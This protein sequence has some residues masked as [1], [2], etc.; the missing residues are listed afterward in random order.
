VKVGARVRVG[1]GVGAGRSKRSAAEQ[2]S[3]VASITKSANQKRCRCAALWL[4]V[5]GEIDLAAFSSG[6]MTK[7]CLDYPCDRLL[8]AGD[9]IVVAGLPTQGVTSVKGRV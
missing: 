3:V 7:H 2:P 1:A 8:G 6:C 4:G 5:V 9:P